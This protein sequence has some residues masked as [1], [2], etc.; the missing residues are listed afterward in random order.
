MAAGLQ[1]WD[2]SGNLILDAS[3]RVMRILDNR[4]LMN[5]TSSSFQDDRLKGGGA[6]VSFQPDSYIGYLSG[7][8]IH[9]QFSFDTANGVISWTYAAK[10]NT[11]YDQFVSGYVY[12]IAY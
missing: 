3:H 6:G 2:A 7:G 4:Q 12:F 10:N 9:P 5:G 1:V 8:L 11:T